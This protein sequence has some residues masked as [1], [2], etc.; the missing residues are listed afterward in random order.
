MSRALVVKVI[1]ERIHDF[2]ISRTGSQGVVSCL[3]CHT[4]VVAQA[5]YGLGLLI[6]IA[7]LVVID[8]VV[9]VI[10]SRSEI[11]RQRDISLIILDLD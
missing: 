9:P 1:D 3:A 10:G 7:T 2:C 6:G 5:G 11:H 8:H 4:A